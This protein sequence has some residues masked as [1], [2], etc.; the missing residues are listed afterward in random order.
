MSVCVPAFAS[1]YDKIHLRSPSSSSF[2]SSSTSSETKKG[3]QEVSLFIHSCFSSLSLSPSSVFSL[4][5]FPPW[6]SPHF[7][8]FSPFFFLCF[9]RNLASPSISSFCN[10]KKWLGSSKVIVESSYV[11]L[12]ECAHEGRTVMRRELG[13]FKSN[14]GK[15]RRIRAE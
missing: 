13:C 6:F 3:K 1:P 5:C 14:Q 15:F 2:S 7:P 12:C 11:H 4:Q 9:S 10:G 8:F